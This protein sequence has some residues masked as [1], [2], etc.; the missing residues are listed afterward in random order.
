MLRITKAEEQAVRLVMRLAA[1]GHRMTLATLARRERLPEPTVAKLLGLLRRGGVV[2]AERGRN[3]GYRLAEPPQAISTARVIKAVGGEPVQGAACA[4]PESV[5]DCPRWQDCGL[6]S[7]WRHLEDQ[8]T[9]L[10]EGTTVADLLEVE[11]S[12][13]RHV[14]RVWP[15]DRTR[16]AVEAVAAAGSA[17][18]LLPR[19]QSGQRSGSR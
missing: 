14:H 10:L 1:S 17:D 19:G 8:V 16:L 2:A 11:E 15:V 13:T 3:G 9:R 6:R 7:V 12:V 5:P 4:A 18:G